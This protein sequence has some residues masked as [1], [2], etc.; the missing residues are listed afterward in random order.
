M[1]KI[2][3]HKEILNQRIQDRDKFGSRYKIPTATELKA[4][5]ARKKEIR[6]KFLLKSDTEL[7]ELYDIHYRKIHGYC[8]K[9][10]CSLLFDLEEFLLVVYYR[11]VNTL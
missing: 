1:K 7:Q 2:S 11:N 8:I 6:T 3:M 9:I 10:F 5:I 4:A